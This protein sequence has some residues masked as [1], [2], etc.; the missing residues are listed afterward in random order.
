MSR[1]TAPEPQCAPDGLPGGLSASLAAEIRRVFDGQLAAAMRLRSSTV[2]ERLERLE[3]LRAQILSHRRGILEAI[4]AD[5]GRPETETEL[6]ELLPL[7]ADLA[8]HRRNLARWLRA[9]RVR[10]TVATLGTRAWVQR[11]PRGR[12]LIISPWNYPLV[13]TLGPLIPALA[14]GNTAVIKTSELAPHSSS[15]L[16][17]LI[18][19]AFDASEVALFEGDA[20]VAGALLELPFDHIFFTGSPAVGRVVMSA[21]ARHLSS[22]TLELGG[23]SPAII[24]ASADVERA[25][26]VIAW[27]KCLNAGQTCIAPDHLYVHETVYEQVLAR[28]KRRLADWYGPD[29]ER[30]PDLARIVNARHTQRLAGLLEDAQSRGAQVLHG[31]EVAPQRRFLGP[32]LLGGVPDEARIM[33]EEIFGPLLPIITYR[34]QDDLIGRINAAPKPLAMYIWSRR[35]R[36]ARRLIA[37]TSAGGTCINQVAVQFL[38]HNLPFGGVNHSGIGS[39]HGEWGIRAFSHERAIVEAGL[40][41]SSA[42]FPPYGARARCT[43]AL[44]RRLSAWLG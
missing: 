32:T 19:A 24:D 3:R 44:L 18:R 20:S 31:G 13:L 1:T 6:A 14:C 38:Q 5:L 9:R 43:V 22:I 37:R 41:L 26:D 12:A 15:L 25:A 33:Q 8:D 30:S 35:P 36:A 29:P 7:L 23:K 39:Y 21:A 10:P 40:Q 11:E 17:S 4:Q 27:S 42:L 28:L 16:A 2:R 34:S